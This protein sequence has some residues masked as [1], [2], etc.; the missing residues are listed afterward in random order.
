MDLS[1]WLTLLTNPL[2][3]PEVS[4]MRSRISGAG[5]AQA[6]GIKPLKLRM[7]TANIKPRATPMISAKRT[8]NRKGKT[9]KGY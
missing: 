1:V 5:K 7:P 9:T 2:L 6:K 4:E 3:M 8:G